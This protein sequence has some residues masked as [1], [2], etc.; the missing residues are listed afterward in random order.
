MAR[1]CLVVARPQLPCVAAGPAVSL[2]DV[3]AGLRRQPVSVT[4]ANFDR[5]RRRAVFSLASRSLAPR[6]L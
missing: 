1:H 4:I 3:N 6:T 5:D 2:L